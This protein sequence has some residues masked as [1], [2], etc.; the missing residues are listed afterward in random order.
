MKN[1]TT[2]CLSVL[3]LIGFAHAAPPGVTITNPSSGEQ[4]E[5]GQGVSVELD[6]TDPE[7]NET[8]VS[9]EVFN[10]GE[11]LGFA[12][13]VDRD[14][15]VWNFNF[16]P[17]LPG[18]FSL[19]AEATDADGEVGVSGIVLI[20][21]L[22]GFA[23]TVE[24]ISVTDGEAFSVGSTLTLTAEVI[25]TNRP[26]TVDFYANGL[27]IGQA[28]EFPYS[29]TYPLIN[30]D[31]D[32]DITAVAI[33]EGFGTAIDNV[34]VAALENL[35]PEVVVV[36]VVTEFTL[37]STIPVVADAGD[38]DGEVVQVDFFAN[39][40]LIGT[41]DEPGRTFLVDWRPTVAATF[42]LKAIATD[43]TGNRSENTL[44]VTV[45]PRVG[46]PPIASLF[47]TPQEQSYA[48]GSEIFLSAD[49]AD[50]DGTITNVSFLVNG[51]LVGSS[52][53][54][55]YNVRYS[56][57]DED[58]TLVV[59]DSNPNQ[60]F[61]NVTLLVEDSD[62]NLAVVTTPVLIAPLTRRLPKVDITSPETGSIFG[63]GSEIELQAGIRT[64]DV[65]VDGVQFYENQ[66]LIGISAN[67]PFQATRVP[68][69]AGI[70]TYEAIAFY[71]F[72]VT[73][74][75]P[76]DSPLEVVVPTLVSDLTDQPVEVNLSAAG[77]FVQLL[78]PSEGDLL[79]LN[80]S[81]E[82][83]ARAIASAGGDL[84]VQFFVV[85]GGVL[86][87]VGSADTEAPFSATYTP[88][89][90]GSKSLFARVMEDGIGVTDSNRSAVNVVLDTTPGVALTA[91]LE[92]DTFGLGS[93]ITLTADVVSTGSTVTVEFLANGFSIGTDSDFPYRFDWS[94]P[95]SGTFFLTARV[96]QAGLGSATSAAR[97][98]RV[99]GNQPPS[100]V[101][102]ASETTVTEQSTV[103]LSAAVTDTDGSIERVNF[104]VDGVSIGSD[105]TSP[106][107]IDWTP[108]QSGV[109]ELTA[110]AVDNFG[111]QA[112]SNV[113]SVT[114]SALAG[115]GPSVFV[116]HP[117]PLGNGDTINDYSVASNL[118]LNATAIDP[119][120]QIQSVQFFVEGERV[121]GTPV[122]LG[123]RWGI[124]WDPAFVAQYNITATATDDS[125][126][127]STSEGLFVDIGPLQAPLPE[128]ELLAI[129]ALE[130]T[131]FLGEPVVLTAET[132]S[133]LIQVDRVDFYAGGVLLGTVVNDPVA[134]G[135]QQFEFTW[136]PDF[137][138]IYPIS[139]RAVQV[140]PNGQPFDNSVISNSRTLI[141]AEPSEDRQFI[142][143]SYLD[144]LEISLPVSDLNRI[145]DDLSS[146]AITQSG[147]IFNILEDPQF[148]TFR[149]AA[150]TWFVMTGRFPTRQELI[151]SAQVIQEQRQATEEEPVD[152]EDEPIVDDGILD[153]LGVSGIE[154]LVVALESEFV[155][156]FGDPF[157]LSDRDYLALI[158]ENKYGVP[159]SAQQLV[160]LL[161]LLEERAGDRSRLVS[162]IILDN[163]IEVIDGNL[164]VT[165]ALTL[166]FPPNNRLPEW[167]DSA[168]LL[169]NLLRFRPGVAEVAELSQLE[170]LER[171]DQVL[172][173]PR[174]A[175]RFV[176]EFE[177]AEELGLGWMFSEW[178]GFYNQLAEPW[179]YH[180]DLDWI[181]REDSIPVDG[182]WIYYDGLGW[183]WTKREA[184]P[185]LWSPST[186]DWLYYEP[187]S[188]NPNWF[189]DFSTQD[190][191]GFE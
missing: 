75:F 15:G 40:V 3:V 117:L 118:F 181:Y 155:R 145:E 113:L 114:V 129:P 151:S 27:L 38:I 59:E 25:G 102:S 70:R 80:Q 8:V 13:L 48:I 175:A 184:Y 154:S 65:E 91:P 42:E 4:F 137:A 133:G 105:T 26:V 55:P 172:N 143:Q 182:V 92:G 24:I 158:F 79:S 130:G 171:I 110:I 87:P 50:V 82:L 138:G 31:P 72:D 178:F 103:Q 51:A 95:S 107:G 101:L 58:V 188:K 12:G 150:M 14:N 49:A 134:A 39:N 30:E 116:D 5:S 121:P 140:E 163:A 85:E 34:T 180:R 88:S 18:L 156:S 159:P 123:N 7:G 189:Y 45:N 183:V 46:Q 160:R 11:S 152:P 135:V 115:R 23:P 77:P 162:E 147:V 179:L 177:G 6:V 19:T 120:G 43:N 174:Y 89:T 109:F 146:G 56:F 41:A 62:G 142:V 164:S 106:F 98:V 52:Q 71:S 81:V 32:L 166:S 148:R 16:V 33:E 64:L 94:P 47:I 165:E 124:R 185:Y 35:P 73:Y 54:E 125:G 168:T 67:A 1:F 74:V 29:L 28:A 108:T 83:T 111:N 2:I 187:E 99:S 60:L 127:T 170:L 36:P 186:Q 17:D 53:E 22:T 128:I 68:D 122:R 119:D 57:R 176:D 78:N 69:T 61:S 90:T 149:E 144:M 9:V 76:G 37:G 153:D 141:V 131:V 20:N 100:I 167:A 126:N 97:S 136:T 191:V 169:I 161:F 84:S 157:L 112:T 96:T 132:D 10:N 104:F 66:Q 173:D 86:S 190:W 44:S 63:L 139:T 93:I 21:L